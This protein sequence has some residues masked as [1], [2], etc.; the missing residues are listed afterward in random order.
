VK[1]RE[2]F[3]WELSQKHFFAENFGGAV[4]DGRRNLFE[5][6]LNFSGIAFLT[7]PRSI[8]PLKSRMR[9]RTSSHTDVAWDFDYDT[10]A[11]K[12]TSS[13]TFFDVHEGKYFGGF[14]YA[15]L[16]APGRFHSEV[17]NT[18]T[19]T[20]TGITTSAISDFSQ[21]RVL[22][23]YG[24]PSQPGLSVATSAGLDLNAG[25]AQDSSGVAQYIT[26]QASYNW[27]CCGL[28]VEYRKYDLGTIRDEGAYR[29]NFTLANIGTAGNLRRAES[30]F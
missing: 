30:L 26:I 6:T 19:N 4:I 5:T 1:Q 9:F 20:A 15:L 28:T 12:F 22:L 16:N 14:S 17:I 10:G 29:F 18:G 8:S 21:M 11:N 3:S 23:G 24:T 2:W 7:E 27:N 25:S 13:N